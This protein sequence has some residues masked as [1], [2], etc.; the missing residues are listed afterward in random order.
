VGIPETEIEMEHEEKEMIPQVTVIVVPASAGARGY[1]CKTDGVNLLLPYN[2]SIK[3]RFKDVF[4]M[5]IQTVT[6]DRF[7]AL[8]RGD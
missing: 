8:E 1:G 4:D 7:N 2:E 6:R 5:R 3:K